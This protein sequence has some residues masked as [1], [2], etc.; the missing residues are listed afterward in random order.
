MINNALLNGHADILE[1]ILTHWLDAHTSIRLS[2]EGHTSLIHQALAQA[3]FCSPTPPEST[4][5]KQELERRP[6]G[7]SPGKVANE[8]AKG[9]ITETKL[10][11]M[12]ELLTLAAP[13]LS[14]QDV[15]ITRQ[16]RL[17][18]SAVHLAAQYGLVQLL[19]ALL[20]PVSEGGFG[21]SQLQSDLI[22]QRPIHYAAMHKH[23]EAFKFLLGQ[24]LAGAA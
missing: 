9:E 24:L 12:I 7:T 18:R 22:G 23:A 4:P 21:A 3:M 6:E 11:K 10:I 20:K 17:G 19:Q 15:D 14:I 2:L 8:V 13:R 16:D 5:G 1:Y